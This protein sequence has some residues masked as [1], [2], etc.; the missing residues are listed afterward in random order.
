MASGQDPADPP[1]PQRGTAEGERGE[2]ITKRV[3]FKIS[4]LAHCKYILLVPEEPTGNLAA[5]KPKKSGDI[6]EDATGTGCT[7]GSEMEAG[8]RN[9]QCAPL[10]CDH[11]KDKEEEQVAPER[12]QSLN[13]CSHQ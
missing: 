6:P 3:F 9:G 13:A 4:A 1:S 2:M 10:A 12:Q 5:A 8:K 11:P 7:N